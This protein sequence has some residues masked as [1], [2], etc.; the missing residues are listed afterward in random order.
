M[1]ENWAFETFLFFIIFILRFTR[2]LHGAIFCPKMRI[3]GSDEFC[4]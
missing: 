4:L 3:S 2:G 1:Y